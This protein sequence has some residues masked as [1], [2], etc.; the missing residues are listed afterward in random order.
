MLK[1]EHKYWE[2]GKEYVVGIDEAG[3][4]PLAGPVVA[5]SV[6]LPKDIELPE[7]TDSKKISEKKRERLYDE[8]YEAAFSVGVGITHEEEIDEKNVLQATYQA[9][10]QSIGDLSVQP[11]ILL[12]DGN[13][14]DI[15]HYE[16]ENII[17]G[18]QKSLSIAAASIIAKVTRDRMMRQYEIVFPE[19]GFAKH[20]GYGTKQHIEAIQNSKASPI[21]R[22]S[23]N[24]ISQYLP[25]F[26]YYKR[27]RLIGKLGVQLVA[28]KMIRSGHEILETNYNVSKVGEIDIISRDNNELVFTEVKTQTSGHSLGES[29]SHIDAKKSDRILNAVQNYMD[30]N[31]L[32]YDF[33]FDIGEVVLGKGK[34]EIRILKEALSVINHNI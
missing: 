1:F 27:N 6:I 5:A 24:P 20:K 22:K 18:D 4:G 33:R 23:F 31:D 12:V 26:A 7:V 32:D 3:R 19:Y 11:D 2:L 8:I 14:A 9:M 30:S 29:H 21:H 34:P 13:K 28:C 17:D 25:S 15:K 16:Q 10:R